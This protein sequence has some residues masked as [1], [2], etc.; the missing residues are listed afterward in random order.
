MPKFPDFDFEHCRALFVDA[1]TDSLRQRA[2]YIA[3]AERN[4]RGEL[5]ATGIS[6]DVFPDH[7]DIN[8]SLRLSS[9]TYEEAHR[10]YPAE[11]RH[12][13]FINSHEHDF[14]PLQAARTY[15]RNVYEPFAEEDSDDATEIGHLTFLSAAHALLDAS[16]CETLNS[17][18]I[19]APLWDG[20]MFPSNGC[21]EYLVMDDN[22]NVRGNYC[23]MVRA[24]KITERLL[25][26]QA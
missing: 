15:M 4:G 26:D 14:A 7:G 13:D 12:F 20:R 8:L 25:G 16:V 5:G 9:D 11:W 19:D 22:A 18:E 10:Y 24:H 17:L 3:S 21:F 6:L 1:V 2:G 23:E